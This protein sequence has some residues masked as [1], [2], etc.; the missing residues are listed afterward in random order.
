M[1]NESK[2]NILQATLGCVYNDAICIIFSKSNLLY[3]RDTHATSTW[4]QIYNLI[5]NLIQHM[6][7]QFSNKRGTYT[8][9]LHTLSHPLVH[10]LY[11]DCFLTWFVSLIHTYRLL[12]KYRHLQQQLQI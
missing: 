12:C 4:L 7:N 1:G 9:V 10:T 6:F 5:Y 11:Y 3:Y 8:I 2:F